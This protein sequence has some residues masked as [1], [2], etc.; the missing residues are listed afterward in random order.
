MKNKTTKEKNKKSINKTKE[1][2]RIKEIITSTTT[3]WIAF[4]LLGIIVIVLTVLAYQKNEEVKNRIIANL[5]IPLI[6]KNGNYEMKIDANALKQTG[7]YI[8]KISNYRK[9]K[10]NKESSKYQI[11]IENH[12]NYNIE[13]TKDNDE[14]NLM[15]SQDKT[16]IQGKIGN[17]EKEEIYFYIKPKDNNNKKQEDFINV[18]VTNERE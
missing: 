16:I 7:I 8:L 9:N 5:Y 15:E 17:K 12:A 10:I 14:K 6:E 11:I 3:L 2:K 4:I 13:V 18:T 1:K